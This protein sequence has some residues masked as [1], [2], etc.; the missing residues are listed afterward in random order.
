MSVYPWWLGDTDRT[1][2]GSI[3]QRALYDEQDLCS[4]ATRPGYGQSPIFRCGT[5]LFYRYY[6][7]SSTFGVVFNNGPR[8]GCGWFHRPGSITL[9]AILNGWL[10]IRKGLASETQACICADTPQQAAS[11]KFLIL[12]IEDIRCGSD[13][14]V[15]YQ[16]HKPGSQLDKNSIGWPFFQLQAP[17]PRCH[18][19]SALTVGR[20]REQ[21][22]SAENPLRL[23]TGDLWGIGGI[24]YLNGITVYTRVCRRGKLRAQTRAEA[25]GAEMNN[26][27]GEVGG[28]PY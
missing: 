6:R 5:P 10:G 11:N 2:T 25:K 26:S 14:N 15:E 24:S 27:D 23:A 4:V 3:R 12:V 8:A 13:S 21:R 19:P 18:Q 9:G 17:T 22:T 1:S 16:Y 20:D 7:V 28:E